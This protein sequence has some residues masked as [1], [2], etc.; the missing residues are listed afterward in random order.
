MEGPHHFPC[1]SCCLHPKCLPFVPCMLGRDHAGCLHPKCPPFLC[2]CGIEAVWALNPERLPFPLC[3]W[4]RDRPCPCPRE[5]ALP[6]ILVGERPGRA[7]APRESTL[8]ACGREARQ[9]LCTPEGLAFPR[10]RVSEGEAKRTPVPPPCWPES[11]PTPTSVLA[12]GKVKILGSVKVPLNSGRPGRHCG[13]SS[14]IPGSMVTPSGAGHGHSSAFGPRPAESQSDVQ[15]L[16]RPVRRPR[17]LQP[18]GAGGK[19]RT[20]PGAATASAVLVAPSH[21][22]W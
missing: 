22:A 13:H 9:G 12:Q 17:A 14:P 2:T 8:C 5:S 19:A 18:V 21:S 4:G 3:L 6:S 7:L 20:G 10:P 1:L 16:G 15:A 11:P